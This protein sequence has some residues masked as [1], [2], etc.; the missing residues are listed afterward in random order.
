MTKKQ[1]AQKAKVSKAAK[2]EKPAE[3]TEFKPGP[4][5]TNVDNKT[6]KAPKPV[7]ESISKFSEMQAKLD[8]LKEDLIH[9]HKD[10]NKE[11]VIERIHGFALFLWRL[12]HQIKVGTCLW[13]E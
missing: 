1:H 3:A 7:K 8:A 6:T 2:Q 10:N 5:D 11:A 4:A 12:R 9:Y 13:D